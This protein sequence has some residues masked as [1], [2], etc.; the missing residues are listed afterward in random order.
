MGLKLA[1]KGPQASALPA[2][3]A[4]W[5]GPVLRS[6][7]L[8]FLAGPTELLL[9]SKKGNSSSSQGAREPGSLPPLHWLP[10]GHSEV[11]SKDE[12][13][14]K[15]RSRLGSHGK[16]PREP[17]GSPLWGAPSLGPLPPAPCYGNEHTS[18]Q[19]TFKSSATVPMLPLR[20]PS[21]LLMTIWLP[22]HLP[23][24][25]KWLDVG[26]KCWCPWRPWFV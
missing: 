19:N 7:S 23:T 2:S 10:P 16:G 15:G 21:K 8:G 20:S 6:R 22:C 4:K 9:V 25:S 26:S 1:L 5:G 12:L 3:L 11:M 24:R 18:K 13:V 14:S 17:T